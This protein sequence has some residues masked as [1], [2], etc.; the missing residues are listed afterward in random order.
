MASGGSLGNDD[1]GLAG[2][3]FGAPPDLEALARLH[4]PVTQES[5]LK[6][7]MPPGPT[8]AGVLDCKSCTLQAAAGF[9]HPVQKA[10]IG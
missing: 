5:S 8:R 3:V 9:L 1:D 7:S 6:L 2:S 4:P 10:E